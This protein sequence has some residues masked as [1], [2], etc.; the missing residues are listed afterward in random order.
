M[1]DLGRFDPRLGDESSHLLDGEPARTE[2][3]ASKWTTWDRVASR[4]AAPASTHPVP[5]R[6]RSQITPPSRAHRARLRSTVVA[7]RSVR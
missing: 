3:T 1:F 6:L 7:S 2:A 4:L 5:L